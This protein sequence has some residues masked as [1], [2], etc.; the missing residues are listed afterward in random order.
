MFAGPAKFEL[1]QVVGTHHAL[2]FCGDHH[3]D[4]FDLLARHASGDWGD[5][6]ADDKMA[7]DAALVD[8]S[9]ILSSYQFPAGRVWVLTEATGDDDHRA[10]TCV[11]LPSDY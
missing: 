3:I 7:N 10:S 11:M 6:T 9:R 5:L 1:G 2:R 4:I 8:C